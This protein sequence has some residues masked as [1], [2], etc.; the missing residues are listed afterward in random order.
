MRVCMFYK[1]FLIGI[2]TL[3][4]KSK[5]GQPMKCIQVDRFM[6]E[7]EVYG[8]SIPLE[9]GPLHE[10]GLEVVE[11]ILDDMTPQLG[12]KTL[13]TSILSY[14]QVFDVTTSTTSQ[15]ITQIIDAI[16]A[17]FRLDLLRLFVHNFFY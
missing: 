8:G 13:S 14:V 17:H 2:N 3:G 16:A 15:V 9:H 4:N 1:Y 12:A 6:L 11:T 5:Q 7:I 10:I